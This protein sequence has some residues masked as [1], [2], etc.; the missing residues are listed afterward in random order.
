MS[1]EKANADK[2]VASVWTPTVA[3]SQ[4]GLVKITHSLP[5]NNPAYVDEAGSSESTPATT[6]PPDGRTT[7]LEAVTTIGPASTESVSGPSSLSTI[8][9]T[10]AEL[11]LM[12]CH[13]AENATTLVEVS[14][15][16]EEIVFV[17]RAHDT[18]SNEE[19][20]TAE[21][22]FQDAEVESLRSIMS[23]WRRLGE[24]QD[25]E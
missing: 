5:L 18:T 10:A 14:A 23:R 16:E 21:D 15:N 25:P 7:F 2:L 19:A 24:S 9:A 4:G 12:R 20:E 22:P 6:P 1:N 17:L 3:S 13:V 8:Y 11:A